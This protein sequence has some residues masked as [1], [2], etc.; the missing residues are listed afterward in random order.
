MYRKSWSAFRA[1][2]ECQ[3]PR[4]P[5]NPGLPSKVAP[6]L[7][8][9]GESNLI[10][11]YGRQRVSRC[12]DDIVAVSQKDLFPFQIGKNL[13]GVIVDVFL[14]LCQGLVDDIQGLSDT[15]ERTEKTRRLPQELESVKVHSREDR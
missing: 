9:H 5:N 12:L 15:L 1:K 2:V 6:I 14:D 3:Q 11:G 8:L 13:V 4:V 7:S 10:L